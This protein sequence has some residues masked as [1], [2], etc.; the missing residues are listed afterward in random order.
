MKATRE[1]R[2]YRELRK[3]FGVRQYAAA[4][5]IEVNRTKYVLFELGSGKLSA[6]ELARL[7][8]FLLKVAEKARKASAALEHSAVRSA[9]ESEQEMATTP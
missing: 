6:A 3:A 7:D 1:Y 2:E 8:R 9:A 4:A 5:A